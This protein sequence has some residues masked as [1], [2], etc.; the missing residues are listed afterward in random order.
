MSCH[1]YGRHLHINIK[2]KVTVCMHESTYMYCIAGNI[3]RELSLADW[4]FWK[5]TIKPCM[6]ITITAQQR[7]IPLLQKSCHSC[8]HAFPRRTS[9]WH[10]HTCV[11]NYQH[12]TP[13]AKL[14]ASKFDFVLLLAIKFVQ[15]NSCQYFW[16]Y[17]TCTDMWVLFCIFVSQL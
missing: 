10:G 5:Q 15:L 3:G 9:P 1:R 12:H 14:N 16:L 7:H 11:S 13:T 6:A 17:G 8:P 2:C 4:W